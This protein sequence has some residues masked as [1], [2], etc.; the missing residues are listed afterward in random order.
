MGERESQPILACDLTALDAHE[1]ERRSALANK[2]HA[3]AIGR[4]ELPNGYALKLDRQK[5]SESD[6]EA[7]TAL[8]GKC[9]PFLNFAIVPIDGVLWLRLTG[10]AG[11]KE[12]LKGEIG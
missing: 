6:I 3:A 11:V 9:C 4:R 5:V 2:V 10:G 1:R 7:W 8:E 12:F